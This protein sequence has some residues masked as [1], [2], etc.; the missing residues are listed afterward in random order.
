MDKKTA[1]SSNI[2]PQSGII[3]RRVKEQLSTRAILAKNLLRLMQKKGYSS[4]GVAIKAHVSQRTVN[5]ME[6][7]RHN[8]GIDNIEAVAGVFGL[9]A[10]Q[11]MLPNLP[12]DLLETRS[13][14]QLVNNYVA[15]GAEG[16]KMVSMVAEREAEYAHRPRADGPRKH[17]A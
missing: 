3:L 1:S 7:A 12:C 8:V 16:R 6:K 17:G 10:W 11:L 5:N 13:I 9:T 15:S 2:L 4:A 14:S